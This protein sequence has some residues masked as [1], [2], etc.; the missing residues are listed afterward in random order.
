MIDH[1][2]RSPLVV[3]GIY[4]LLVY[5]CLWWLLAGNA[6]WGFGALCISAAGGLSLWLGVQPL[7]LKL[8]HLPQFLWF[9]F[10]EL[11][12]GAWDV[13]HRALHPRLPIDPAWVKF[14][15]NCSNQRVRLL[16][17][18]MVG[19]L[20]GTVATRSDTTYMYLHVL[21]QRQ[22]WHTTIA[23]METHLTQLFGVPNT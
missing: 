16:L 5:A 10:R 7:Y 9:F 15:F 14:R 21:D 20:P 18:A 13:A 8:L 3:N 11:L 4:W 23:K 2:T 1:P 6:G 12:I 17:P 19:L 22:D